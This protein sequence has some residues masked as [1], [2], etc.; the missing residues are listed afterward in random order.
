MLKIVCPG[1]RKTLRAPDTLAGKHVACPN[2]SGP[3]DLPLVTPTEAVLS[4]PPEA[5]FET[6]ATG[7][8]DL[9]HLLSQPPETWFETTDHRQEKSKVET[10]PVKPAAGLQ[11]KPAAGP[12]PG[13]VRGMSWI[14]VGGGCLVVVLLG[15]IGFLLM[16][17]SY[18]PPTSSMPN[19]EMT[20][21]PPVS[22]VTV[23]VVLAPTPVISPP[24][25]SIPETTPVTTQPLAQQV[26]APTPEM[27]AQPVRPAFTVEPTPSRSVFPLLVSD[28]ITIARALMSETVIGFHPS[29]LL[30]QNI[31]NGRPGNP[32]DPFVKPATKPTGS[33]K[34]QPT[35]TTIFCRQCG[36]RLI[37]PSTLPSGQAV[38]CKRCGLPYQAN[39]ADPNTNGKTTAQPTAQDNHIPASL[40]E[41]RQ[42]PT[43]T[44]TPARL[45]DDRVTFRGHSLSIALIVCFDKPRSVQ[46]LVGLKFMRSLTASDLLNSKDA[47]PRSVPPELFGIDYG[48][49]R[50]GIDL[51]IASTAFTTTVPNQEDR[52]ITAVAWLVPFDFTH[53][54]LSD[55][56]QRVVLV[57]SPCYDKQTI[58]SK[59]ERE[60]ARQAEFEKESAAFREAEMLRQA[61]REKA[62]AER[63]A[64]DALADQKRRDAEAAEAKLNATAEEERLREASIVPELKRRQATVHALVVQ[65]LG[66]GTSLGS[67][68][69]V[70]ILCDDSPGRRRS[71]PESCQFVG[72]SVG[73]EMRTAM[74]EASRLVDFRF[75]GAMR[76]PFE[77]SFSDKYTPKDGGSAGAAFTLG[78]LS[79]LDGFDIDPTVAMT[80]DIVVNGTI[81]PVGFVDAKIRAAYTAKC[82]AV[83]IP[84]SN[85]GVLAD[86]AVL[87]QAQSVY[88][89]QV[90]SIQQIDDLVALART[91]RN[92][93]LME[94]MQ[95]FAS[96]QNTDLFMAATPKN[97]ELL[98]TMQRVVELAP[99]HLSARNIL[100]RCQGNVPRFLSANMTWQMMEEACC[101]INQ[102]MQNNANI[103]TPI[104]D[105]TVA[106]ALAELDRLK[107]IG[108][109]D[110]RTLIGSVKEWMVAIGK[111]LEQQRLIRQETSQF[112][113]NS[114]SYAL[115]K[116]IQAAKTKR[117]NVDQS[118]RLLGKNI[119]LLE[120]MQGQ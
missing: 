113:R 5:Q 97:V 55:N 14:L 72:A 67:V 98:K 119:S 12:Q 24:P 43:F 40:L 56:G 105:Q 15:I 54:S 108:D 62:N 23:P 95:L 20:E 86:M 35:V 88:G 90:F 39:E 9:S 63:E 93:R 117:A 96:V 41:M 32:Q 81:Q 60:T 85:A 19:A 118:M 1:C 101:R 47:T 61:E 2:C 36:M 71:N 80:G 4:Q 16:G 30:R 53:G 78:M 44:T 6:T 45:T 115:E 42:M 109:G 27:P 74:N 94:A 75:K 69:D 82:T 59:L 76:L 8:N 31:M 29:A 28:Q 10:V 77:C 33:S 21:A 11:P 107:T 73:N 65:Q 87:G 38:V 52:I 84:E 25:V 112:R 92:P 22:P 83:A 104:A 102:A 64:A 79:M 91:D 50:A 89:I 116:H 46:D 106:D 100:L 68:L 3:I 57:P 18:T 99:N 120:R 34:D 7:P 66:N 13:S 111:V 110:L 48:K 17:R 26:V 58:Q 103:G 114:M 51:S 37:L 70:I 49:S